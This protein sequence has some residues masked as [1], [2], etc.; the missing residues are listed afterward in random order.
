MGK[1]NKKAVIQ[2]L[3]DSGLDKLWNEYSPLETTDKEDAGCARWLL[4]DVCGC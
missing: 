1:K 3:A 4:N 2:T